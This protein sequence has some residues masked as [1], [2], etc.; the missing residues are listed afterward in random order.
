[1]RPPPSP[2]GHARR[3]PGDAR[4]WL[5]AVMWDMDGT[6]VD[7]EPYWIRAEY[8]LVEAY[9]GTWSDDLAHHLVGNALLVSAQFII[10]HSPV[11]LSPDEVVH[12][13]IGRVVEQV[14]AHV[15]WRPGAKALL[16]DLAAHAVPCALVTMSWSPLTR[17]VLAELPEGTFR[18]VIS[19]DDVIHGKPHPEPY[20]RAAAALG[21]D[22]ARC[23]ALEDSET[24][25]RSAVAAGYPTLAIPH[26]VPI[27][28]VPGSLRVATL[29]GLD[30]NGLADLAA[31]VRP[32]GPRA[33]LPS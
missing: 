6:L 4:R 23:V 19:G 9:D 24:G 20:L 11:D 1:M 29:T 33:V 18:S 14:S 12:R 28:L 17:A 27:P 2:P 22:P 3:G 13:L 26:T 16:D 21:V 8:E 7:T 5:D 10:D 32:S 15:P 30:T 25:V 31:R